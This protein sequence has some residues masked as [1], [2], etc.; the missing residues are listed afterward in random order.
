[1][2]ILNHNHLLPPAHNLNF[3]TLH[4]IMVGVYE[5]GNETSYSIEGKEFVDFQYN[6]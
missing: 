2:D 4:Y 5:H 6:H 3:F 1:M